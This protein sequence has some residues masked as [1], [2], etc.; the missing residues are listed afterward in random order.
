[1]KEVVTL[2]GLVH[3]LI[4]IPDRMTLAQTSLR[5]RLFEITLS[6]NGTK[7]EPLSIPAVV[8]VPL[9]LNNNLNNNLHNNLHTNQPVTHKEPELHPNQLAES[10]S[11][12]AKL[13][14]NLT[15][16]SPTTYP[17]CLL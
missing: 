7:D 6:N 9:N 16:N 17:K 13:Q 11:E 4:L 12:I 15:T 10:H 14:P 1:M 2:K 5:W 3:L 8:A